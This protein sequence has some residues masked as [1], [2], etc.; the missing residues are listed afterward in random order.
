MVQQQQ[1]GRVLDPIQTTATAI[2]AAG[3]Y[4]ILLKAC[5]KGRPHRRFGCVE[6]FG[7]S[8]CLRSSAFS[9]EKVSVFCCIPVR[10]SDRDGGREECVHAC[11]VVFVV[12]VRVFIEKQE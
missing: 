12:V 5:K 9:K 10:I 4:L 8:C 1:C 7:R 2:T 6:H 3:T 11:I